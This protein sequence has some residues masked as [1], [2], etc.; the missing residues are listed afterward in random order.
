MGNLK[1]MNPASGRA[2]KRSI[3]KASVVPFYY[4]LQEILRE[5]IGSG[6]WKPGDLLPSE[7]QL[8]DTFHVSRT[9]IRKALDILETEGAVIRVKGKGTL[10][11]SPKFRYET[12]AG[13]G[14]WKMA[15]GTLPSLDRVV[16]IRRATSGTQL[17]DLLK[18]PASS[19]V[20]EFTFTHSLNG[21]RSSLSQTFLR[22]DAS[23]A[24]AALA[25]AGQMPE[26]RSGGA[27]AYVQLNERYGVE[28]RESEITIEAG[29]AGEFDSEML[30]VSVGSP[31]FLLSAL[32]LG[33]GK[34]LGFARTVIRS[35]HFRFSIV[36]HPG[37]AE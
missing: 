37:S 14:M 9:V 31:V 13:P 30:N 33:D 5:D 34:P 12:A 36:L 22:M 26:L 15:W 6:R 3:D 28:I 23:P 4:Q 27:E 21:F 25:E 7:T 32:D 16:D 1:I 11:A 17:G 19:E 20:F 2:S 18:V 8:V 35:D 29:V 24:I 10:V